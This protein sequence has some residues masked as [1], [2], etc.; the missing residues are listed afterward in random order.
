MGH[1]RHLLARDVLKVLDVPMVRGLFQGRTLIA[2]RPV[3]GPYHDIVEAH[4][5]ARWSTPTIARW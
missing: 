4:I 5:V 3:V 1:A 2:G